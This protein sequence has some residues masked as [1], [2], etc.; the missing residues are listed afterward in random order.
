MEA[1]DEWWRKLKNL[2]VAP[3]FEAKGE[4]LIGKARQV[5]L[6]AYSQS[7]VRFCPIEP[8]AR[9]LAAAQDTAVS[10]RDQRELAEEILSLI[11]SPDGALWFGEVPII[12]L[13]L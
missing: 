12:E 8:D 11:H 10:A 1:L 2:G 9:F 13:G 6:D 3:L 5:G 7:E 4:T